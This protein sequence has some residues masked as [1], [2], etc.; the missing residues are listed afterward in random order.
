MSNAVVDADECC[1][2]CGIAPVDD[3]K[4]KCSGG[5]DLVK[6]CS[7]KCQENHREQQNDECKRR[8]AELRD[9][10]LFQQP[11][12]SY[13]GECPICFLPLPIDLKRSAFFSMLLQN[14]L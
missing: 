10:P 14:N 3:I 11:D 1:A 2:S 12:E 4:L 8:R 5:C 9:K 6:C 13:L 7:D